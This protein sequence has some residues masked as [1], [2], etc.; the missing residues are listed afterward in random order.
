MQVIHEQVKQ[1]LQDNNIQYK[2]RA[3]LRKREMNFEVGDLVLA[4]LRKE[5]FT[6]GAYNKLKSK[7]IGPCRILRKFSANAYE[8]EFKLNIHLH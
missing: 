8:I 1:Q 3:D 6:K 4:H 2:T 5:R 7:K